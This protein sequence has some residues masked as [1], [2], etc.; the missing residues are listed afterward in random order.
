MKKLIFLLFT[1]TFFIVSF[2][3]IKQFEYIQYQT[4]NNGNTHEQWNIIIESGDPQKNKS[5]NFTLLSEIAKKSKTN[6]Q[7]IS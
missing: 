7:R 1:T 4:F 6:L 5:E 3:S 2:L